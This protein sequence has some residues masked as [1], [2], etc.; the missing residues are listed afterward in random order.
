MLVI[1]SV[2]SLPTPDCWSVLHVS[3]ISGVHLVLQ[4]QCCRVAVVPG[5][6]VALATETAWPGLR[7]FWWVTGVGTQTCLSFHLSSH[8]FILPGR[9]SHLAPIHLACS[10]C[11]VTRLPPVCSYTGLPPWWSRCVYSWPGY[12]ITIF[13]NIYIP[14]FGYAWA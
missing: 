1:M 2:L 12:A 10:A 5:T 14:F 13:Q 9:G 7:A 4:T 8:I 3:C 11:A 6:L